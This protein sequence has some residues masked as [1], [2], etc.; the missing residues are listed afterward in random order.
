MEYFVYIIYSSSINKFYVGQTQE[1]AAR[2]QQH[3]TRKNLGANDWVLK[4]SES[5]PDRA[6]AVRR[7]AEIKAKKSRRY[8]EN[9]ISPVG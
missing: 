9:L 7:E 2:V 8:I 3:I 5:F 6:S 4:H 1:L